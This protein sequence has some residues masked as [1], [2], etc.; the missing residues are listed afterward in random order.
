MLDNKIKN[1]SIRYLFLIFG[2]FVMAAGVAFSAKSDLGVSPISSIPYVMSMITDFTIGELTAIMSTVL[3]IMQIA[4]LRKKF[5]KEQILQ[6]PIGI[7]FG[8]LIDFNLFLIG[9]YAP[10]SYVE[11]WILCLLSFILIGFGVFCEVK[12]NVVMLPG[13][14]FVNAVTKVTTIKFSRNKIIVDSAMVLTAVI[15][16]FVYF[17]RLHGIREGT[18]AA[19]VSVGFFASIFIRKVKIFDRHLIK[20]II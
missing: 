17:T 13:E 19:A 16:S 10:T 20:E 8:Y 15:I 12:A 18:I 7:L 1:L 2:L 11:Q 4:I 14:G 9:S 6:F 5:P 3:L